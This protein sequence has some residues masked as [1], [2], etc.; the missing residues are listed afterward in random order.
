MA[1]DLCG[2]V[3]LHEDLEELR[4]SYRTAGIK[5]LCK[6]CMAK[7]NKYNDHARK[8]LHGLMI[9]RWLKRNKKS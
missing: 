1:C 8:K 7:A 4:D 5:V 3:C 2:K 6:P 9:K